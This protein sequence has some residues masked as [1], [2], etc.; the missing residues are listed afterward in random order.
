[1]CAGGDNTVR[2]LSQGGQGWRV[3]TVGGLAGS[4]GTGDG[5][6]AAARFTV[7]VG[8]SGSASGTLYVA[9]SSS[10]TLRHAVYE[11]VA[12]ATSSAQLG[13]TP[14]AVV[15]YNDGGVSLVAGDVSGVLDT[16]Y[17]VDGGLWTTYGSAFSLSLGAHV[18]DYYSTDDMGNCEALKTGY[19]D[20]VADGDSPVTVAT[21]LQIDAQS[22]WRS[23][24]QTV[25]LVASD[26]VSGVL[27]TE[28]RVDGGAWTPYVAPFSVAGEGSH[29][30]D[31]RS[32]DVAG[33][34]EAFLTGYVN[35]DATVP[36]SAAQGLQ[37]DGG[38]GWL[39]R[40][41]TVSLSASDATGSG[42][43]HI[44]YTVDGGSQTEYAAPFQVAGEGSHAVRYWAEDAVGNAETAKTGF[45][46]IDLTRPSAVSD[47]PAGWKNEVVIVHFAATDNGGSGVAETQYRKLGDATWTSADDNALS[48]P[49]P[50]DGANDAE[51]VYQYRCLDGAGNA[52]DTQ[53]CTV[54]IDTCGPAV[55]DDAP[56]VWVNRPVVVTI[57]AADAGAG[58][59]AIDYRMDNGEWVAVDGDAV[60]VQVPAPERGSSTHTVAYR[61]RD[62]LGNQSGT[63][64][65]TT[66]RMEV[67][68]PVI[69]PVGRVVARRGAIA[70]FPV[71]VLDEGGS[72]AARVA[73]TI[74]RRSGA[75]A[76]RIVVS[77]FPIGTVK[78]VKSVCTLPPG[79]YVYVVRARDRAGNAQVKA[80]RGVLEVRPAA[81]ATG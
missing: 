39:R 75:I 79:S 18:V 77:K 67:A 24:A 34:L 78:T 49:A 3:T 46:N 55:I 54:R 66:I 11:T 20:V 58:V 48:V 35:I 81:T 10:H 32:R 23:S 41:Q 42:V 47:A 65:R 73:I 13:V 62:A 64:T 61:A 71:K 14:H 19:V 15:I 76:R 22:G 44:Y 2:K 17:R 7:P 30:I 72:E 69:A 74:Y 25:T 57:A 9:D 53:V 52:S 63:V 68:R 29:A 56:R 37:S 5:V 26:A 38:S 45:V 51:H 50:R 4:S 6:G 40:A 60:E 27:S 8:V 1:V 80:R 21:G 28:Y 36:S 59:A 43:A 70:R 12:P 31:F 16:R 33:N